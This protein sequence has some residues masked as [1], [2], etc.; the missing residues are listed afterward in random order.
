MD[1]EIYNRR[2]LTMK[3]KCTTKGYGLSLLAL[4]ALTITTAAHADYSNSKNHDERRGHNKSMK[5]A[6]SDAVITPAA[7]PRVTNGADLFVSANFIYWRMTQDGT[8]FAWTGTQTN[9]SRTLNHTPDGAYTNVPAGQVYSVGN[10]WAPGFKVGVGLDTAHDGWDVYA[11]Y[12]WVQFKNSNSVTA[13]PVDNIGGY[14]DLVGSNGGPRKTVAS[15]M[16]LQYNKINLEL[17]RNF[18]FS[19]YL[20]ARPHAGVTG[21][22]LNNTMRTTQ[23][24]AENTDLTSYISFGVPSSTAVVYGFQVDNSVAKNW[25]LG[26]RVGLDF[27]WHFTKEWS[28]YSAFTGNAI[29]NTYSTNT[30]THATQGYVQNLTGLEQSE[31][32]IGDPVN[33]TTTNYN[34]GSDASRVNYVVEAEL[35]LC[36]ETFFYDDN[37]H[38]AAKVGWEMQDWINYMKTGN[39]LGFTDADLMLQGLNVELRFDF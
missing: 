23:T 21:V 13:G 12:T 35:G 6:Q 31:V 10:D 38:F 25:G 26:A 33:K 17:G 22:W 29:W 34:D 27:G 20:T 3:V 16:S 14:V 30:Y 36:W 1:I 18:Y 28:L 4:G 2:K 24:G 5:S 11:D 9:S 8:D 39:S 19:Q 7:G 15:S 32:V 37:Y